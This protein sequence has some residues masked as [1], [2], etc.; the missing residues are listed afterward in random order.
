MFIYVGA[1]ILR[2]AS[3]SSSPIYWHL[4][5][6]SGFIKLL[7]LGTGV[8][9]FLLLSAEMLKNGKFAQRESM[10]SCSTCYHL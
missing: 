6:N 9:L 1:P 2:H 3:F 8:D 7:I 5:F 4:L 10:V